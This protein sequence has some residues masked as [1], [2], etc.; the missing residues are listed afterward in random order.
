MKKGLW[1]CLNIVL[2]LLMALALGFG[3]AIENPAKP[4]AKNAGRIL[5][6]TEAW[7]I[8]DETGDFYFRYPRDLR[9]SQ[10]GIIFLADD[11]QLLKFSPDG[12][13]LKNLPLPI[14]DTFS[15]I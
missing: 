9:I 4:I 8:T 5:S 11:E 10:E 7:R 1:T 14:A 3:Q 6:L 13:F 2:G 12:R 15:P